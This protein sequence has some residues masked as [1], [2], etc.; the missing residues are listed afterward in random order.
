MSYIPVMS[1]SPVRV[2]D[3]DA[4]YV[5]VWVY[6]ESIYLG[7]ANK[8]ESQASSTPKLIR[9]TLQGNFE[10]L[11]TYGEAIDI[12]PASSPG[13]ASQH[14]TEVVAVLEAHDGTVFCSTHYPSS[15]LRK[16]PGEDWQS[17]LDTDFKTIYGMST[18]SRGEIFFTG[19]HDA[20]YP[21]VGEPE[22]RSIYRSQDGGDTWSEVWTEEAD[23]IYGIACHE[24]VVIVGAKNAI[25]KST[26]HGDSFNK[27]TVSGDLRTPIRVGNLWV[28]VRQGSGQ[29]F[30]SADEGSTWA[31][32]ANTFPT[33][34][35]IAINNF[36]SFG[37]LLVVSPYTSQQFAVSQDL[38]ATWQTV[39]LPIH[40]GRGCG[41]IGRTAVVGS[42]VLS[43]NPFY[44][45][46]NNGKLCI[47]DL[48]NLPPAPPQKFEML[49]I[50]SLA[51]GAL[52]ELTE[53]KPLLLNDKA[54][55]VT[56]EVT[57]DASATDG[58]EVYF[59]SSYDNSTY[60]TET[61]T[62]DSVDYQANHFAEIV[63]SFAAGRVS[64]K[65]E[66]LNPGARFIKCRVKNLDGAHAATNIKVTATM[67]G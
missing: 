58:I 17:V 13:G 56:V 31:Q 40:Y 66:I 1:Q 39:M 46:S 22:K 52:S 23:W 60:D 28:V 42:M 18:N 30:V 2:F 29:F 27:I 4:E 41:L 47:V 34:A 33:R 36:A 12:L 63:P 65:T 57:Y 61:E 24:D 48:S 50:T 37:S 35:T 59:Y 54:V 38:G 25:L 11:L 55:A 19:R 15:I 32:V 21:T 6:G 67:R 49:S 64:R 8:Y 16:K 53:C 51:A 43:D 5:N 62:V 45:K 20:D 7:L 26:N 14:F 9:T 44:D 3:F 10:T